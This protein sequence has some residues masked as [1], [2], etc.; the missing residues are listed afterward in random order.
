MEAVNIINP[1]I[2]ILKSLPL[3]MMEVDPVSPSG[4]WMAAKSH[5]NR[6]CSLNNEN[7]ACSESSE[8]TFILMSSALVDIFSVSQITHWGVLCGNYVCITTA[9]K[10]DHSPEFEI[11][12][13]EKCFVSFNKNIDL[14]KEN[15]MNY[16]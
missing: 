5:E 6:F 4:S 15:S 7:K 10:V 11:A 16:C 13:M 1:I 2:I 9:L 12:F 8:D 14:G 3:P